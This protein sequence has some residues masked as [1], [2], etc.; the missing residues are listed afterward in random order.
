MAR[1]L[2]NWLCSEGSQLS[3]CAISTADRQRILFAITQLRWQWGLLNRFDTTL[4]DT[5][6]LQAGRGQ[7]ERSSKC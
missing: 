6:Y 2:I 5:V 4:S 3:N 1:P 7:R